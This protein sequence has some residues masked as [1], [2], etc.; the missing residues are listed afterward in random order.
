M[1]ESSSYSFSYIV[2]FGPKSIFS[3]RSVSAC[4]GNK[5]MYDILIL[6]KPN[7]IQ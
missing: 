1:V 3:V 4:V 6:Y 7:F 5:A 2:L